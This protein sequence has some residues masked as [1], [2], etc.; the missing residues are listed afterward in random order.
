[1]PS[2]RK[3]GQQTLASHSNLV[4]HITHFS[5]CLAAVTQSVGC[6]VSV[7][8]VSDRWTKTGQPGVPVPADAT[9]CL[10][11]PPNLLLDGYR[12]TSPT[13]KCPELDIDQSPLFS[14]EVRNVWSYTS[15]FPI[16]LCLHGRDRDN[17][18]TTR[19][20][21]MFCWPCISVWS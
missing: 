18:N 14:P 20:F 7:V 1:M 8:E 6:P 10:W 17:F 9:D 5:A 11:G 16:F 2:E 19:S 12:V 3:L 13:V 15:S 4:I 21:F